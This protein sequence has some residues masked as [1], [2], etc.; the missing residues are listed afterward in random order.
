MWVLAL[1]YGCCFGIELT[2]DNYAPLYFTDYFHASLTTAGLLAGTFGMMNL[3]AR[4]LGGIVSDRFG[5][6]WGLRGRAMLLGATILCEGFGLVLFSR[7]TVLPAAVAA[8]MLAGLFVKMSNGATYSLVPFVNKKA[9]GAVAGI[10]GAG[11]NLGAVLAGF[12]FK[13]SLTWPEAL[14]ILGGI[15]AVSSTLAFTVR[16]SE[17]D[18]TVAQRELRARLAASMV[19]ATAGD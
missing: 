14:L 10:V 19:P 6:R 3:F 12:L 18:E 9:I 16:F 4:A 15:V 7:M 8:M 2:I 11:G 17:A 5:L 1:L 13:S